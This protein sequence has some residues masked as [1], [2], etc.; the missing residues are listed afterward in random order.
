MKRLYRLIMPLFVLWMGFI[1]VPNV[2][3]HPLG[4]FTINHYAGLNIS[5]ERIT[6]DFVLDLAEIPAFQ[7]IA[8][9][10]KNKNQLPDPEEFVNYA[11][12]KCQE[13]SSALEL[14][15]KAQRTPLSLSSSEVS[16][17][18]GVGNLPTLRLVCTYQAAFSLGQE[19]FQVEF[20]DHTYKDR[21]GWREIVV[22]PNNVSLQGE[23]TIASLSNRLTTYPVDLLES[24][25][26]Q[27][28]IALTVFPT[29]A[30]QPQVSVE[31]DLLPVSSL[32]G[33]QEDAFTRLITLQELTPVTVAVALV[34]AFVMG[35]AHALTPGHGKTVVAAYLVGTRGTF[36]HALFL[37]LTTTITH[38]TGVFV[39]GLITLFASKYIL[40]EKLLPWLNIFSGLFVVGIGLSLFW[41]R[42]RKVIP[43]T[44]GQDHP[45]PHGTGEPVHSHQHPHDH[46]HHERHHH[47]HNHD[48]SH[49]HQDHL[50]SHGGHSHSHLPPG[51]HGEKVTWRDLLALGISGGLIP[52]PSALIVLLSAIALGRV[53]F[54]LILVL[55][56][57][58]GL[59]GLLTVIGLFFVY[60][61]RF[62]SNKK[63]FQ[64]PWVRL[65]P[66]ASALMITLIGIGIVGRALKDIGSLGI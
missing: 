9:F 3:A 13:L 4:N 32:P 2:L 7:E 61:G 5:E 55:V 60:T 18:P 10:D 35:A 38:T 44:A 22:T 43:T 58:L 53:G 48:H 57:S 59:A 12:P 27:Q 21:L 11:A 46:P 14:R 20:F 64:G 1:L 62:V 8:G 36:K 15:V 37:G 28:Q 34:V 25:L 54:G 30:A 66:I 26:D 50:H 29:G 16:F 65:L 39:L 19:T 31:A 41:A 42:I 23:Y 51:I 45:H 49:E 24:P 17:P 47:D 52:C 40:P 56:F 6:L 33:R 63:L